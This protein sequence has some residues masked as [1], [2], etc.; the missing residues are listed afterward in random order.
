MKS[1]SFEIRHG[2]YG[3]ER[4]EGQTFLE[5]AAMAESDARSRFGLTDDRIA[6]LQA[7]ES[8]ETMRDGEG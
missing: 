7:R 5:A 1:R 8:V 3:G 4:S 2:G 6:E